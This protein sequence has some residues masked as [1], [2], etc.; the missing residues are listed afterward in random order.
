MTKSNHSRRTLLG[1]VGL[2]AL[3]GCSRG[4]GEGEKG[5]EDQV[6]TAE[7]LSKLTG[8][9]PTRT[10]GRTGE[11]VSMIGL[12]GHHLG[13]AAS[14]AEA[15]R[16][17]RYAIERGVTFLDNCWDYHDGRSELWMG[18]ALADGYRRRV[19]L[20][21]K[22][23]GRTREAA[24]KQID[25]SLR[26]LGTDVIDLM[27]VHEV[28]RPDDAARVFG[29]GGAM[30][31]LLDA[32]KAGKVRYVGFTGHKHPD[33]HLTMLRAAAE[34][35]V[36]FDAVQMPLNVMDPHHASFEKKVLPELVREGIGVLGMKPMGSGDILKTGRATAVEC[37]HYA[38]SLPTSVVITGCES[39]QVLDQA[40]D[41]AHSFR[42]LAP[43][44]IE[45]LLARTAA[46]G[47]TGECERFKTSD[48]FDATARHPEWLG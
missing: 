2:A 5:R 40:I 6:V 48:F 28:I 24:A 37:L 44:Q 20:M 33:I 36:R 4:R 27:Q 18:K 29:P 31:A 30:E 38:M 45:A 11:R 16:L 47:A 1:A 17:A 8:P 32:K 7:A 42:P 9:V 19:F 39:R 46:P 34:H 15:V 10:L 12:G 13:K 41:A 21:T 26:R 14:E 3:G 25:E 43:A 35:G 22:F 23:D